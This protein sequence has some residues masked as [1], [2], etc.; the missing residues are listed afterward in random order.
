M[1]SFLSRA[2]GVVVDNKDLALDM[3]YVPESWQKED[4]LEQDICRQ[5]RRWKTELIRVS[6]FS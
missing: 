5:Q 4:V 1:G 6:F 3:E 2:L